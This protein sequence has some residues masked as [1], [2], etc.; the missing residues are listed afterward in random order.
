MQTIDDS[1][2]FNAPFAFDGQ[3]PLLARLQN[4]KAVLFDLFDTLLLMTDQHNCYYKSLAKLHLSLLENGYVCSYQALESAY[5]KVVDEISLE[6]AESLEEPPFDV[7]VLK[8]LSNLGFDSPKQ[9]HVSQAVHKF[10]LEF[11]RYIQV[12]PQAI[13][14]IKCLQAKHKIGL[15][16]NLS[17]SE[18]AWQLLKTYK[19]ENLFDFMVVS[20]DVNMRK[21]NI[22]LFNLALDELDVNASEAVFV[23]DTLETDIKGALNVGMLPVHINRRNCAVKTSSCLTID[24]LEELLPLLGFTEKTVMLLKDFESVWG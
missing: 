14:V 10:C 4:V 3:L 7:Y 11:N 8:T 2:M 22:E 1:S 18:S 20:G 15:I 16:S 13:Q 24:K 21:P 9:A 6:T 12:D 17:F 5:L 23:G 19:L